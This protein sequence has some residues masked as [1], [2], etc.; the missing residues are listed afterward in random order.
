MSDVNN[1]ISLPTETWVELYA[2]LSAYVESKC[3][4]DR[5]THNKNGSRLEETEDDFLDIVED[6][7]EML[8]GF[9][10]KEGDLNNEVSK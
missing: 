5:E 6:V 3:Y 9:F 10:I 4:P 1:K 2:E 8:G 7:E